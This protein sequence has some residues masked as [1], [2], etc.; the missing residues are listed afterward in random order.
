MTPL[1]RRSAVIRLRSA[2]FLVVSGFT[3]LVFLLTYPVGIRSPRMT[4][5][6]I[7]R[8]I[9]LHLVYLRTICGVRYRVTGLDNLPDGPCILASRH[10]SLWET[11]FLPWLLGNPAVFL[12]Q[13]ILHYPV[14]GPVAR[15]LD[16]IGVDRSGDAAAAKRSFEKA[17]QITEAGR[18]V[19]IFPS[20]TRNPERRDKVQGGVGV[21]YRKLQVPCVPI[22]L[23]SG[24]H[25]PF[26]SWLR[27]PGEI[28]VC[29]LPAIPAGLTGSALIERLERDL[30]R[31]T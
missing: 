13:E 14:A 28:E 26:G 21:L 22:T 9:W 2:A 17:R 24:D 5:S 29:I 10:E 6:I 8:Y 23:N 15:T 7:S 1:S 30:Q 12:K 11:I 31:P 3:T 25:W 27:V 18:S 20:G 16:Y 4:W 19:L